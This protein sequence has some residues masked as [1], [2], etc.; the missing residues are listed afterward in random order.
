MYPPPP[1]LS[2]IVLCSVRPHLPAALT[3]TPPRA[4]RMV[5]GR[6]GQMTLRPVIEWETVAAFI[7]A[8]VLLLREPKEIPINGDTSDFRA[9]GKVRVS[10]RCPEHI[11]KNTIVSASVCVSRGSSG[12]NMARVVRVATHSHPWALT[13]TI[14]LQVVKAFPSESFH[15]SSLSIPLYLLFLIHSLL[16]IC[17]FFYLYSTLTPTRASSLPA[18]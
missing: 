8:A 17:I 13:R 1:S 4:C 15:L 7:T 9:Q 6:A 3:H 18:A 11:H 14:L 12:N 5:A 10:K 16:F 2:V